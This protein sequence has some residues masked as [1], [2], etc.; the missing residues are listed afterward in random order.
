M[1]ASQPSSEDEAFSIAN[2]IRFNSADSSLIR[3]YSLTGDTRKYTISWWQKKH[4]KNTLDNS[5]T[6]TFSARTDDDNHFTVGLENSGQGNHNSKQSG[7]SELSVGTGTYMFADIA[8]WMHYVVVVDTASN[9][10]ADRFKV[11]I[12]GENRFT[13]GTRFDQHDNTEWNK[14]GVAHTIGRSGQTNWGHPD[15]TFAEIYHI[16][17]LA[18]SP[19]AFGSFDSNT[20]VWNPK[21]FALPTPNTTAES[22]TWSSSVST[23]TGVFDSGFEATKAFDGSTETWARNAGGIK[24]IWLKFEPSSGIPYTTSVRIYTDRA[25][26]DLKFNDNAITPPSAAGWI[27]VAEG[28]GTL[29]KIELQKDNDSST[30]GAVEVDGVILGDGITDPATR[31]NL[32]DG[33]KWSDHLTLSAG[34]F[35]NNH[36]ATSAFDGY[37]ATHSAPAAYNGTHQTF[38]FPTTLSGSHRI[39]LY[40]A[41]GD[42]NTVS[43]YVNGSDTGINLPSTQSNMRWVDLG[44]RT[45]VST[46]QLYSDNASSLS[47]LRAIEVDGHKLIDYAADNSFHL[48]F[49]DTSS[50]ARLGKNL[51]NRGIGDSSVNG[52]KPFYNTVAESDGYDQGLTKASS[53]IYRSDSNAAGL[54]LAIPGDVLTDEHDHVTNA[55]GS[56]VTVSANGGIAVSTDES[57]F[58]GKSI[59][60]DGS[61]DYLSASPPFTISDRGTTYTIEAWIW[62]ESGMFTDNTY[63]SLFSAGDFH[64]GMYRSGLNPGQIFAESDGNWNGF[65]MIS[66][67]K[68]APETWTHLAFVRNGSSQKLFIDGIVVASDTTTDTQSAETAWQ[69]GQAPSVNNWHGY[70]SDLKVYDTA[71]YSSNFVVPKRH[72]FSITNL[73]ASR[74]N[75]SDVSVASA[76]GGLPIFNTTDTYGHVKGSGNRTDGTS[77]PILW[78]PMDGSHSGTTFTDVSVN[79]W[80]PTVQGGTKTVT[81]DSKFYG[82]SG[83]FDGSGDYLEYADSSDWVIGADWTVELWVKFKNATHSG[84]PEFLIC[85]N[86]SGSG[87]EAWSLHRQN[88]DHANSSKIAFNMRRADTNWLDIISDTTIVDT[89]WHHIAVSIDDNTGRMFIDGV[90]QSDTIT[91]NGSGWDAPVAMTI[92]AM[93]HSSGRNPLEG[94]MQDVRIYQDGKYTSTFTVPNNPN[95]TPSYENDVSSD[96]P[97][98]NYCVWNT[99]LS[100]DDGTY[101]QGNL[102][103]NNGG[104]GCAQGTFGVSSGKW[105][106]ELYIHTVMYN[107]VGISQAG[108][109]NSEHGSTAT[110]YTYKYNAEKRN[111]NSGTS[112][113]ASWT[114]GDYIGVALDLDAGT[115]IFYKNGVSQG[116]AFTGL[117]GTFFPSSGR[118]SGAAS[119]VI[120][121]F[122]QRTFKHAAP[123]GYK[124]LCSDNLDDTFSGDELNKPSSYFDIKLYTGNGDGGAGLTIKGLNFQPDLVWIKRRDTA[125][126]PLLYDAARGFGVNKA[127]LPNA[128]Y[129][130]GSVA[131]VHE[132]AH[133]FLDAVTSDGFTVRKGSSSGVYANHDGAT[134]ASWNWDAGTAAATASTAGDVT[135]SAQW[136]NNTAGFSISTFAGNDTNPYTV[137]H[138]LSTKP[139]FIV[140]RRY[141]TGSSSWFIQHSSTGAQ[142][143]IS[144]DVDSAE[145]D[146]SG[147]WNDAEP[148]NEKFTL[149]NWN[150][151]DAGESLVAYCWTAIP[152]YSKFGKA[153]GNGSGDGPF[154]YC[155]FTPKWILWKGT[156]QSSSWGIIDTA[157]SPYNPG[158]E[159]LVVE[160]N[161]GEDADNSNWARDILSNGF[162]IRGDHAAV[163]GDGN[164]FIYA[165]FAD[166]PFKISRAQ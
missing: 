105:Y 104:S 41:D 64:I 156:D 154:V 76:T 16:D 99:L 77:S 38:T 85:Q 126:S 97:T 27:T 163:N 30:L 62:A 152:G 125:S 101:S 12:N 61:N 73:T 153:E 28:R 57:R 17:G 121:N 70:V 100:T 143:Y 120:A 14:V 46:I 4:F 144:F 49:A 131:D 81:D 90:L 107:S 24:P 103:V 10:Q 7:T 23:S 5:N 141:T 134:Y 158:N 109:E 119:V 78:V 148:D 44:N 32:N 124:T 113:G 150:G 22:P 149:G 129:A 67:Q 21:A 60:F 31:N 111:N 106:W 3:R 164:S 47:Y 20:G 39:R 130:M 8:A 63:R 147:A 128:N 86:G 72:D 136:V 48:N 93:I 127:I 59:K 98:N 40:A 117:S 79:N 75:T 110:M 157:R 133:G 83:Y 6:A 58:Y 54:K 96:S 43:V 9:D 53:D 74:I 69:I 108:D 155:G 114:T 34:S 71:I 135:P 15:I 33:T 66:A 35:H 94:W 145:G 91:H 37:L 51:F 132:A 137:G 160:V 162:K 159:L 26:N 68:I 45:N 142:K 18:L 52:G 13:A 140:V 122:G 88:S 87:N 29:S 102:K 92:G 19:A 42:S 146:D 84:D 36:P 2:S 55:T 80:S 95:L 139:D 56:A 1:G 115:L 25:H 112:Y 123:A 138:G 50:N 89:E 82:S 118:H 161:S 65:G 151:W 116:T 166:T 11:Y 165:A